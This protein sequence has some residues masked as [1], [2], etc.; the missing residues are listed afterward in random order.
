MRPDE[1]TARAYGEAILTAMDQSGA[2]VTRV[3]EAYLALRTPQRD[4]LWL[5]LQA[6]KEFNAVR[7]RVLQAQEA[8]DRVERG[9]SRGAFAHIVEEMGEE[10]DHY[11]AYAAL[12]DEVLAGEPYPAEMWR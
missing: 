4:R 11:R 9:V 10:L 5:M 12:L 6:G 1:A 7:R 8:M 3:V 2:A